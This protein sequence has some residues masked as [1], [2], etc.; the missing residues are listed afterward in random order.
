MISKKNLSPLYIKL[1]DVAH[2]SDDFNDDLG[3]EFWLGKDA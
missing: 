2:I 1:F 3:D